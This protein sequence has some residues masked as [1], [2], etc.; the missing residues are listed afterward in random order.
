[1]NLPNF[2]R[3]P[4][5][6][7]LADVLSEA[8]ENGDAVCD[9]LFEDDYFENLTASTA[10]FTHCVFRRVQFNE[11]DID[12][13]HFLECRFESCDFSGFQFREG[14]VRKCLFSGSRG[15]GA[16]FQRMHIKDSAFENCLIEY[17]GFVDSKFTNAAFTDC[18]MDHVLFHSC[19]QKALKLTGCSM[20][21]CEIIET[22]FAGVDLSDCN[23]DGMRS[24]VRFLEGASVSLTQTPVVLALCGI[25]LKT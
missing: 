25:K 11:C 24:A 16:N 19:T 8:V 7:P 13:I 22:S 6:K 14:T 20:R 10:E 18:S 17:I 1:M 5:P 15:V 12:R 21:A 9:L 2:P 4:E 23:I 3:E